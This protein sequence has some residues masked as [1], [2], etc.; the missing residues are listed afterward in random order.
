[1]KDWMRQRSGDW[2]RQPQTQIGKKIEKD[3]REQ[4]ENRMGRKEIKKDRR[5]FKL[6]KKQKK[7]DD[8]RCCSFNVKL[9]SRINL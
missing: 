3:S 7:I 9:F 5:E 1:M 6:I 4:I 2:K 8:D